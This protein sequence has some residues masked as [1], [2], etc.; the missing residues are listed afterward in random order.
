MI[1]KRMIF[2]RGL[3]WWMGSWVRAMDTPASST[4]TWTGQ[5]STS[6][7]RHRWGVNIPILRC[8]IGQILCLRFEKWST[9]FLRFEIVITNLLFLRFEIDS[10]FDTHLEIEIGFW[11]PEIIFYIWD[12]GQVYIPPLRW[13]G[14]LTRR[15]LSGT[16]KDLSGYYM[17]HK[18]IMNNAVV[19]IY[20]CCVIFLHLI[21]IGEW[22]KEILFGVSLQGNIKIVQVKRW[23]YY[24]WSR[25][26][27]FSLI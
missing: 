2:F 21:E 23:Y 19:L 24:H 1:Y 22:L 16:Y 14:R 15:D 8:E 4:Q 13:D 6:S 12:W 26:Q 5:Q 10:L 7:V 18:G 27:D 20:S 25:L 9:L 11:F 3:T 17:N